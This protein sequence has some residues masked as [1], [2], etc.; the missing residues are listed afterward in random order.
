MPLI[1]H[2][3]DVM[4]RAMFALTLNLAAAN[5]G[6]HAAMLMLMAKVRVARVVLIEIVTVGSVEPTTAP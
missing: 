2:R 1:Q 3:G 4:A 5:L 6:K